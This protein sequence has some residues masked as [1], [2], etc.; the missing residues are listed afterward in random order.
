MNRIP[1]LRRHAATLAGLAAALLAFATAAPAA[2]ASGQRVFNGAAV[3]PL[4]QHICFCDAC[5]R[6]IAVGSR[7]CRLR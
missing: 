2:L 7:M 3:A 4:G 5:S 1:P 6:S